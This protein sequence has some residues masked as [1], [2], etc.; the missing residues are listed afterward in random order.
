MAPSSFGRQMT[1]KIGDEIKRLGQ[2][3]H[4]Q[5]DPSL[6]HP[7]KAVEHKLDADNIISRRGGIDGAEQNDL[8]ASDALK[9]LGEEFAAGESRLL[10][11][12][13]P[14]SRSISHAASITLGD[15]RRMNKSC[16]YSHVK[17]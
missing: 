4:D 2:I 7:V 6:P 1:G 14:H 11:S 15:R 9:R 3:R 8:L 13:N 10:V 5:M 17:L 12:H 16:S